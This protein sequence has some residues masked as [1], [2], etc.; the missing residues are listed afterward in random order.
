MRKPW[1]LTRKYKHKTQ[2]IWLVNAIIQSW[3]IGYFHFL[4]V[5]FLTQVSGKHLYIALYVNGTAQDVLS[6]TEDFQSVIR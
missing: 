5:F 6:I 4:L 1:M 2:P 3:F